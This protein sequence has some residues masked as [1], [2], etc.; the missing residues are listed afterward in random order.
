MFSVPGLSSTVNWESDRKSSSSCGIFLGSRDWTSR[1]RSCWSLAD[2][3][4]SAK[5]GQQSAEYRPARH[6]QSPAGSRHTRVVEKDLVRVVLKNAA[7]RGVAILGALRNGTAR[8]AALGST[9][10][11]D[12][13]A[14]MMT[15]K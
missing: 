5:S 11:M 6:V 4:A 15:E 7:D 1:S 8:A 2:S 9:R 3:S 13:T 14:N 12:R 10:T